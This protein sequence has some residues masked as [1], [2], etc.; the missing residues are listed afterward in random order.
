MCYYNGIRVSLTDY[1]RLKGIEKQLKQYN[2]NRAMQ[3]GFAYA[4]YP[5]IV[6]TKQGSDWEIDEMEWGFLPGYLKNR[7]AVKKFREGYKDDAGKYHPAMTTLNAM[8]EEMLL[9]GK[10]YREAALS[11]RCLVLSTGFYEWRHVFPMGKK[12]QPLKTAIKYPYHI[13]L[14]GQEIFYMAGIWQSWNDKLTGELVH[15]FA[16]TTTS[17]P[18][19]HIMNQIHN[20][21]KRMPT[22]LN[23]NLAEE[24][25]SEGLTESRITEIAGYQFPSEKMQAHT[26]AKDFREALNPQDKFDYEDLPAL[27][28]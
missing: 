2:L 26:I 11:R 3:S 24:W 1:I 21:K 15:T 27:I 20:S 28:L 5:V 17:A 16:L 10:M 12:G 23:D 8:S 22:I 9:P 4:N 19:G 6:P 18:E 14:K 25:L 13:Y 7:E